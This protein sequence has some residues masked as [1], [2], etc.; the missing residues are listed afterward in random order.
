MQ[1][2]KRALRLSEDHA[3]VLIETA[4]D[5]IITLG[6][7]GR[8]VSWN[9]G[10]HNIFGFKP[11]EIIG[12]KCD[13][14]IPEQG[15]QNHHQHFAALINTGK[16]IASEVPVEGYGLRKNGEVFDVEV[17]FNLSW[18]DNEPFFSLIVRDISKRKQLEQ[19]IYEREER[20]RLLF[21]NAPIAICIFD[22]KGLL[23]QV[24]KF[25]EQCFG[26]SRDELVRHGLA[27]FL[28]PD[29]RE[30]TRQALLRMVKNHNKAGE[31]FAIENRYFTSDGRTIYTKQSVQGVFDANGKI[32]FAIIL[33]E[34]ITNEKQ[35]S[36]ANELIVNKLKDVHLE[37]N[38]FTNM[39]A[40]SK[41]VVPTKLLSDY[42]LTNGESRIASMIY[43][44]SSNKQIAKKL[45]IS[46]NTVKH[47][48]TNLYYKMKVKNRIGL[49]NMI[50]DNNIII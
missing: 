14:I 23:M 29:D 26:H 9:H 8:I 32:S 3:R 42:D 35:L 48:I 12:R 6:K 13:L 4:P 41:K 27:Q 45:Y 5:A 15:R 11:N 10:A 49:I 25:C 19:V 36:L 2:K 44:G 39:L 18:Y 22:N 31:S 37:L 46:V 28:H 47:H 43:H 34:D 1:M 20:L 38:S 17:A 40:D 33:T 30:Q 24:N 50:R 16:P 21:E 7:Q